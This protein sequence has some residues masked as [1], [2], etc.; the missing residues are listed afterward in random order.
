[1][2]SNFLHIIK[3]LTRSRLDREGESVPLD[4]FTGVPREVLSRFKGHGT[5]VIAEIKRASPSGGDIAPDMQ[6]DPVRVADGYIASGAAMLSVLTEPS[7][8][9]GDIRFL[10]NIRN[11]FPGDE[12]ALLMKDFIIDERQLISARSCGADAVLLI[13]AMLD[14][15]AFS[16][17]YTF[18]RSLDLTPLVEVHDEYELDVAQEMN[19]SMIGV[20]NRNLKTFEI[21]VAT[22][23][24]LIR[25]KMPGSIWISESGIKSPQDISRLKEMG[26]DGF[27]IGTSLMKEANPG[28]AL[29]HLLEEAE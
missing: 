10:K 29:K 18:A 12:T 23:E 20:N 9:K 16:R 4:G 22:S 8:F 13:V 14:K 11:R 21:D 7:F 15:K 17:L 3:E 27:L 24:T 25:R 26:F 1:M 19:C 2:E 5:H 28:I 6:M